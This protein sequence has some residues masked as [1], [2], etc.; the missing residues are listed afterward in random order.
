MSEIDTRVITFAE[1]AWTL[2]PAE[3]RETHTGVVVLCGDRA[4][5]VKKP[6]VT[7]FLDF[8]TTAARERA[9]A[10]EL[11]LNRRLAPDVYLGLAHLTD[12]TGGAGEPVLVMRRMPE[13]LRLATV[14][15]DPACGYAEIVTLATMLAEFHRTATRSPRIN[16]EGRVEALRGRWDL[17][18][19]GLREH[20]A[21]AVRMR[22]LVRR[23]LA[24]RA[25]L[26]D[27][28]IAQRRIVDGH[29][30][31]LT[32]DI[33]GPADD[34]RILDCL[35]F[36]DSLRYVDGLDDA[37]F[38]AMDLEFHGREDLAATFLT[39]YLAAA[40]DHPPTSLCEH[41]LGYRA[42]VRAK[43]IG[44]RAAQ[45]DPTAPARARG[46]LDLAVR[47]LERGAVR[48]VLVGGL[49]GTGKS[50]LACML[51]RQSGATVLA[52]DTVRQELVRAGKI[53]GPAGILDS[54]RYAPAAV[55]AVYATL[56]KRAETLLRQGHS[57]ILDASWSDPTER[58]RARALAVDT[59]ADLHEFRCVVDP[60]IA[61][62]RLRLRGRT[63]SEVTPSIAADIADRAAPWPQA[64]VLD[65]ACPQTDTAD[66]A[67]RW[68]WPHLDA[69]PAGRQP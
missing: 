69:S 7:D 51:A 3:V 39:E 5:K 47:H 25:R 13:Q 9:C 45:G 60:D 64:Q 10:R 67:L 49:P 32:D 40:A 42:A 54:G 33:F 48:L 19:A 27:A 23:Y 12:P 43:V 53:D 68:A 37:A 1:P 15:A 17:V 6:V 50:T 36:D 35:D 22:T 63:D 24:G 28:R 58:R 29:G 65:T 61:Q 46:H 26:F 38:L 62:R 16:S 20:T 55:T 59:Y 2:P 66:T 14:V 30:D 4:Y 18:L 21:T 57:V 31:L 52:T 8:G 11:E 34:I 44:I 56:R 41:Y